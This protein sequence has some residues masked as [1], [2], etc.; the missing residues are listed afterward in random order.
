MVRDASFNLLTHLS[1][2]YFPPAY[3]QI[4]LYL[5][6][7]QCV[8]DRADDALRYAKL[9]R[10][11][12]ENSDEP[13][14]GF[15]RPAVD[16]LYINAVRGEMIAYHNLGLRREMPRLFEEARSTS[17]FRNAGQFWKPLVGRDMLNSMARTPRF[18]IRAARRLANEIQGICEQ[19]GDGFTLLLVRESYARCLIQ[20]AEW[21]Q[22]SRVIREELERLPALPH[23]G[24]LHHSLLLK[25]S[26]QAAWEQGD[27]EQWKQQMGLAVALM[28]QAG[29]KHQL[30]ELQQF[31]GN[32]N[33]A[34]FQE[35]AKSG[36]SF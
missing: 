21:K 6:D 4:C 14:P 24:P 22:A 25:S 2:Q 20:Q 13:A 31:Y 12:L 19:K 27:Q 3:A 26:A 33:F 9:A 32:D 36:D 35:S 11:V 15:D 30:R 5:H 18:S 10:L 1:P 23:Y 34:L 28:Q 29:L 7:A 16:N 17:A 8:L